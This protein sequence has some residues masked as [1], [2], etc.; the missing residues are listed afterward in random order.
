MGWKLV[1]HA[2]SMVLNNLGDALRASVVPFAIVLLVGLIFPIPSLDMSDPMSADPDVVAR[3]MMENGGRIALASFVTAIV[4]VFVFSWVAVTWHRFILLEETPGAV[5]AVSD[6]PIFGYIWKSILAGLLVGVAAIPVMLVA[7][8]IM[9]IFT[10]PAAL[11]NGFS[12]SALVVLLLA[13]SVLSFVWLRIA[14]VLP[15]TAIGKTMSFGEGWSATAR[16]AGPIF[17]AGIIIV[18]FNLVVGQVLGMLFAQ[19]SVLWT[20]VNVLL[21]WFTLM[22]GASMLTTLYGHVVEGR[23]LV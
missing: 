7:F 11:G 1:R 2:I 10:D 3:F 5:P 4:S 22:V 18:L 13:G 8:P 14:I 6:R 19:G 12:L 9:G 17:V 20:V 15:A 16:L 23:D 21:Q